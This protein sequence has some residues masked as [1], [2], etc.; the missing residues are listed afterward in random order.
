MTRRGAGAVLGAVHEH[1]TAAAPPQQL[2]ARGPAQRA[3][4]TMWMAVPAMV[5]T[6]VMIV[7]PFGYAWFLSLHEFSFGGAMRFQWLENYRKLAADPLFWNGLRITVI[8]YVVSLVLQLGLGLYLGILLNRATRVSGVL[9]TVLV[10]PFMLPPVVVAMMAIVIFDPTIGVANYLLSSVG[11]PISN[12]FAS[13]EFVIPTVAIIDAWQWT[14]FVALIVLGGLQSLPQRVYEAA[15]I[16]GATGWRVFRHITLP[17]LGPTLVTAAILRSVDLLRF[18]DIIYITTQGGPGYASTTV[19]IY[20]YR[21]GF[22]FFDIGY[23]T[24]VMITLSTIV[25]G[26]VLTFTRLRRKVAW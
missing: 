26:T 23:A 18:F 24:A 19:N 5:F 9:R 21:R 2:A 8:L 10:S 16:D 1:A 15:E 20:A 12:W 7:F 11:L 22:E 13:P 3:A 14:P 25:L 17:L 6:A 4:S